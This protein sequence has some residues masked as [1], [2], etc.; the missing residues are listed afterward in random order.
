LGCYNG[1]SV[2]VLTRFWHLRSLLRLMQQSI[3]SGINRF[4]WKFLSLL[5]VCW[6]ADYL[7]NLIFKGVVYSRPQILGVFRGAVLMSRHPICCF[8]V[9]FLVLYGSM[10]WCK[11][12]RSSKYYTT[13]LSIHAFYRS[14]KSSQVVL[15][16]NLASWCVVGLEWM[17]NRLFNNIETSILQ[18]LE[19][20][21]F[22]SLWWLKAKNTTFVYG[23]QR[24]WS[25]PLHCLGIDW[26]L[27]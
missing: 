22:H 14:L 13:F 2:K 3:L 8:I 7:R 12:C 18:L 16:A 20:V 1:F 19:K 5:G 15:T 6:R 27:M 17:H 24:W 10:D 4:R 25:D 11:W 9:R 26:L 23:S 21:K